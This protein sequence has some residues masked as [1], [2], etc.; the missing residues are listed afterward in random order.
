MNQEEEENEGDDIGGVD[1]EESN[2]DPMIIIEEM[3]KRKGMQC[4]AMSRRW[5]R[6][7]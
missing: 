6:G 2:D 7:R 5:G 1:G 3:D 4:N